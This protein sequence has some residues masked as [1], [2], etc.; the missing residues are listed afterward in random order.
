MLNH[1]SLDKNTINPKMMIRSK[2]EE[3]GVYKQ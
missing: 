2:K 3:F 1:L